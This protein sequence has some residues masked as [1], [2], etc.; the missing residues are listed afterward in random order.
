MHTRYDLCNATSYERK[1][2]RV[3]SQQ[4]K[5][6]VI[7]DEV[8]PMKGY[9]LNREEMSHVNSWRKSS[10]DRVKRKCISP[11]QGMCLSYVSGMTRRLA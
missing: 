11:V 2:S 9:H 10:P 8:V 5:E 3:K 6:K 7:L 4:I 1:Q